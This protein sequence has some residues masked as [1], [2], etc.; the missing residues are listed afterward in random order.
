MRAKNKERESVINAFDRA[1]SH[2]VNSA[3]ERRAML[4]TRRRIL[5]RLLLKQHTAKWGQP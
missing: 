5:R 3:A 4:E 2:T 1:F